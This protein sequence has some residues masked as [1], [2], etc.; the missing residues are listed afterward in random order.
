MLCFILTK[1]K[2]NASSP[3]SAAALLFFPLLCKYLPSYSSTITI[4]ASDSTKSG[5]PYIFQR[6]RRCDFFASLGHL[7]LYRLLVWRDTL[8]RSIYFFIF[9]KWYYQFLFNYLSTWP[10]LVSHLLQECNSINYIN[11]YTLYVHN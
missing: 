11:I 1:Y 3:L 4:R 9:W 6:G 2:A 10:F 8:L 5:H 7:P